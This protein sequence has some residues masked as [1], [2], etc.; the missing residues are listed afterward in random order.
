[1][2]H[3]ITV[4]QAVYVVMARHLDSPMVTA[5]LDLAGTPGLAVTTITP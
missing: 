4:A 1:M 3:S 5:D 2:G